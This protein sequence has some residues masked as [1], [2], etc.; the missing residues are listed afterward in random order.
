[1]IK[2]FQDNETAASIG[3]LSIENSTSVVM[4]SGNLEV[5]RDK[6]GLK[7]A[8]TLKQLVDAVVAQL[9]ADGNLPDEVGAAKGAADEVDNPFR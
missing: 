7:R 6:A 2:P 4:I 3:D 8:R 1:M 9:E 5:A